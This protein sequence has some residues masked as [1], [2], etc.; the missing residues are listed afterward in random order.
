MAGAGQ[1]QREGAVES[2][3]SRRLFLRLVVLGAGAGVLA[4]CTPPATLAPT[5][6]SAAATR[7]PAA[8]PTAAAAPPTT[9][10]LPTAAVAKPASKA[11]AVTE[12]Y[13]R[14][15]TMRFIVG[16]EP[17]TS[18]DQQARYFAQELPKFV[19]GNPRIIVTNQPGAGA[20]IAANNV[21][22]AQPDGLT[23]FFGPGGTPEPQLS[24]PDEV[25][26]RFNEFTRVAAFEYRP[27][28]WFI[29]GDAPYKRVQDA[30][31]GA[32]EFTFGLLSEGDALEINMLKEF[33]KLPVRTV[34]GINQGTAQVLLTFDRKD[35]QSMISGS[36]WYQ[37]PQQRPGWLKDGYL[38]PFAVTAATTTRL[39]NNT[40]LDPPAD[41]KNVRDV[42]TP[43]QRREYDIATIQDGALYR[44]TFMPPKTP[45]AIR[46]IVS[47][48]FAKALVDAN[49]KAGLTKI[50][51][52]EPDAF[53]SG[54]ELDKT[55]QSFDIKDL[56][57]VLV[58]YRP[59]YKSALG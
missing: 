32:Q 17:G 29:L 35:V 51:G 57:A 55:A 39:Q 44:T 53:I 38:Q 5:P 20:V 4:A 24:R 56:D 58:K 59:G 36:G 27:S 3:T 26:Y 33:L 37:M 15:K 18:S 40:E 52:R 2:L 48:A 23:M 22:E 25:K 47:G 6:T 9:G 49:F 31:G 1:R 14:G 8:Q 42:M 30:V 21:W 43:E 7:P 41:L 34:F 46:D 45:S 19:P 16:W 13:Y 54:A 11:P 12:D 50:L 10:T 28:V